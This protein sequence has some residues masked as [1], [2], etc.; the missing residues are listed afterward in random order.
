MVWQVWLPK[1]HSSIS[2]QKKSRSNYW[3]GR[4][5]REVFVMDGSMQSG[6]E[7]RDVVDEGR[8]GAGEAEKR[9]R[10]ILDGQTG[11]IT[12]GLGVNGIN[13]MWTSRLAKAIR[14]PKSRGTSFGTT[15][16][17][18]VQ[19]YCSLAMFQRGSALVSCDYFACTCASFLEL[20]FLLYS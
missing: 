4:L 6:S 16:W 13:G 14:G 12:C 10:G 2:E 15:L 5:N 9:E 17:R 8:C 18:H 1:S 3:A 20:K 7:T 19:R 11:S